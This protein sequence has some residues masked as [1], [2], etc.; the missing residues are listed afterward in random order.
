MVLDYRWLGIIS[1][2]IFVVAAGAPL[3]GRPLDWQD[4]VSHSW[5]RLQHKW[6]QFGLVMSLAVT[7]A[8]M[9]LVLWLIPY[10]HLPIV[11]Y[12]VIAIIYVISFAVI[13]IPMKDRP[14]Q[15]SYWH[16]HFLSAGVIST[17][18]VITMAI[19]LWFG[20]NISNIARIA[21]F[22]AMILSACWP[23]LF[24]NPVKRIF[25]VLESLMALTISVAIILLFVG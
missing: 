25:L 2:I 22:V 13:W 12:G 10:Y 17:L 16:G 5:A 8:C 18:A 11:M 19:V 23:L 9:S 7:G 21:C 24:F 14:G 3:L 1:M 15:H 20:I 4:S 6:L